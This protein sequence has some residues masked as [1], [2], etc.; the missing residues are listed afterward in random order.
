MDLQAGKN[1]KVA[2]VKMT[3]VIDQAIKGISDSI[4][5]TLQE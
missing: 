5:K 3:A 1:I 2:S 4:V